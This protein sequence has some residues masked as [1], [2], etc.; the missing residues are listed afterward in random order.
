MPS[1]WPCPGWAPRW[2]SSPCSPS[3][4]ADLETLSPFSG[5]VRLLARTAVA[6][7]VAGVGAAGAGL[8]HL[9]PLEGAAAGQGVPGALLLLARAAP[10]FLAVA[11]AL[12]WSLRWG[13][14][15][16]I[17]ASFALWGGLTW[18]GGGLGRWDLFA[19][20]GA[21]GPPLIQALALALAAALFVLVWA[22][23]GRLEPRAL[24]PARD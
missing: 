4:W 24:G 14:P 9:G 1:P 17:A 5:P 18:F 22:Q 20:P 10:L 13:A 23:A 3:G 12:A 2:P 19:A 16:A 7:L 8:V 15:G 21:A 6:T 11:W